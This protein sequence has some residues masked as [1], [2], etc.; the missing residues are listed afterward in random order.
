MV[1]AKYINVSFKQF[2][3]IFLVKAYSMFILNVC[4][5]NGLFAFLCNKIILIF[6]IVLGTRKEEII[7]TFLVIGFKYI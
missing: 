1:S 6:W 2:L 4:Q 3:D 5:A 7:T